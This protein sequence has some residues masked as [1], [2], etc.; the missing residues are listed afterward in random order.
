MIKQLIKEH[1]IPAGSAISSY[2]LRLDLGNEVKEV[3]GYYVQVLSN[4]GLTPEQCKLTFA[5]SSK[6]IFEPVGL[7]HLIV[8]SSVAIKDRFFREEPFHVDG[9]LNAKVAIPAIPASDLVVQYILLVK[10]A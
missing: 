7:G 4:G 8:S 2:E 9:F 3:I 1:K 10:T 5:N 6:T